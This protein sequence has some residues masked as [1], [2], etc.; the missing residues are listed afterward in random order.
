MH[1]ICTTSGLSTQPGDQ[2]MGFYNAQ[3]RKRDLLCLLAYFS[4]NSFLCLRGK[5]GIG[6]FISMFRK[7]GCGAANVA[8]LF[9]VTLAPATDQK[10]NSFLDPNHQRHW[11]VHRSRQNLHHFAAFRRVFANEN[12]QLCLQP[13]APRKDRWIADWRRIVWFFWHYA[14]PPASLSNQFIS[15]HYLQ[16]HARS[17]Q[18]HPEI[19]VRDRKNRTN[20][21]ARDVIH[22]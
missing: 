17:V 4:L 2:T 22:L 10:M 13:I 8:K 3:I 6:G 5:R 7:S 14:F 16:C 18:H 21:F 19:A 1:R 12:H 15:K 11:L 9:F 20:L